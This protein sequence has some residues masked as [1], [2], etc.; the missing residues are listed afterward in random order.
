MRHAN[1]PLPHPPPPP[2]PSLSLSN[3]TKRDTITSSASQPVLFYR[4]ANF[5]GTI[6][7]PPQW[8]QP[9][10]M[11]QLRPLPL[12]LSI[13]STWDPQGAPITRAKPPP[14]ARPV[15][16]ITNPNIGNYATTSTSHRARAVPRVARLTL[17]QN[18]PRNLTHRIPCFYNN[19]NCSFSYKCYNSN[20]PMESWFRNFQS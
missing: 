15:R 9:W 11:S 18:H 3:P 14:P 13:R 16:D 12:P 20:I 6:K 5:T 10:R 4:L 2:P 19:S 8:S 7:N 1:P 17:C